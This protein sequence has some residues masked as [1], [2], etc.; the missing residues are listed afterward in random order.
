[1]AKAPSDTASVRSPEKVYDYYVTTAGGLE[2]VVLKDLRHRLKGVTQIRM[3]RGRRHGRIFFHY[4]RSPG[5]L[6]A[7]R[8]V[9]N[10]YARL[11]EVG[12]ITVGKP[13]L[14]RIAERVARLD[15]APAMALHDVLHGPKDARKFALTCTAGRDHRFS[16]GELYRTI[17]SALR[18]SYELV[19]EESGP[20]YSLHLQV[21]GSRA[22]LGLQ[23]SMRRMRARYYRLAGVPGGLEATVAYCMAFLARV[24][25]RDIC[26][27]PMCG[28]GT[29]LIET[30]LG[31]APRTLIGGDVSR[32]ALCAARE[33]ADASAQ[34]VGLTGWDAGRLP[35]RDASA[36]KLLCNLPFGK[37]TTTA[38]YEG[39]GSHLK[40][41]F[42]VLRPGRT[43]VLLTEDK[44]GMKKALEER[45]TGFDLIQQLPVHLRGVNPSIYVL[46]RQR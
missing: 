9:D 35:L 13:G 11:A 22:L 6:M 4:E 42:R 31:F 44:D 23:L 1:M 3:D 32:E 27:D 43:A 30:G 41:F 5:R 29:I 37:R 46:K 18:P 28:S 7:L 8:S 21:T 17:R 15:L 33:N 39:T 36:D 40:E 10:V 24:E 19:P 12:G 20:A 14:L 2:E 34:T 16:A 26:L 38:R 45:R 25:A